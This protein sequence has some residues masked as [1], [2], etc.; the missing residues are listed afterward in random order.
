ML[1]V[2]AA[3][4][5]VQRLK[6]VMTVIMTVTAFQDNG[7]D[8]G[9]CPEPHGVSEDA[10]HDGILNADDDTPNPVFFFSEKSMRALKVRHHS[11]W[12][13]NSRF[14]VNNPFY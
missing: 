9:V 6:F 1:G 13:L 7:L 2:A 4:L 3:V 12:S 8:C 5:L 10:D 11:N 14:R